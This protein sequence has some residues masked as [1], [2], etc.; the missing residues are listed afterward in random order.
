MPSKSRSRHNPVLLFGRNF[1]KH[2]RMLGSVIP[3]SRFLIQQ[4][5]APVDW[6][7]ARVL[8]EFGPGV[9]TITKDILKKMHP[10][11]RLIAIEMNQDFVGY[12]R[13]TIHDPRFE[14]VN[15]SAADIGTVLADRGLGSADY[16]FSGIP[17]STMPEDVRVSIVQSTADAVSKDG[18]F[19]VY[20]FSPKVRS[21]LERAFAS[22]DVGFQALNVPPA[23]VFVCRP[24]RNGNGRGK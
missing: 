12:L 10:Q 24:H 8:V 22:V 17:F 9:G 21:Y 6:N 2:P 18:A 13:E 4:V 16:V 15:G 11:A 14:V 23:Q 20:Q 19:V 5:L 1:L 7:R 3:S